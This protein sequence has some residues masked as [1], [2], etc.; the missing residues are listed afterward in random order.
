MIVPYT[1]RWGFINHG[2][3]MKLLYHKILWPSDVIGSAQ[4]PKLP[5]DAFLRNYHYHKSMPPPHICMRPERYAST[6]EKVLKGWVGDTAIYFYRFFRKYSG[7]KNETI[8]Y[9]FCGFQMKT[10]HDE[11]AGLGTF[12]WI[13]QSLAAED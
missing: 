6:F 9:L 13:L 1:S 4:W 12:N 7:V 11:R 10:F 8:L 5:D 3:H 2:P